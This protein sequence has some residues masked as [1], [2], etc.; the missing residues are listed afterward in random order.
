MPDCS[1]L[2]FTFVNGEII[3][4]KRISDNNTKK[5]TLYYKL[6]NDVQ[7]TILKYLNPKAF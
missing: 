7:N 3:N 4:S 1:N 2:Q 6:P 5:A